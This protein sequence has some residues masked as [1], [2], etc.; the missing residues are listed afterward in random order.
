MEQPMSARV[1]QFCDNLRARLDSVEGRLKSVKTSIQALRVQSERS[2][3]ER[4]DLAGRQVQ[5]KVERGDECW[6]SP[7]AW[8]LRNMV[9][10]R[11]VFGEWR[12]RQETR[13][14]NARA[15][16]AEAYAVGAIEYALD[17]IDE[18]EELIRGAVAAGIDADSAVVRKESAVRGSPE[19]YRTW[20]QQLA[21]FHRT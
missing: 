16:R 2:F 3:G 17:A 5:P 18:A 14:L 12:A 19:R 1:N 8:A 21:R 6:A 9:K 11:A 13:E 15:D 10:L 7:K 4:I 20:T